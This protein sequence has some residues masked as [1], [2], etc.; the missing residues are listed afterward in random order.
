MTGGGQSQ[1]TEGCSL[2]LISIKAEGEEGEPGTKQSVGRESRTQPA[3]QMAR[4]D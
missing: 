3:G 1:N 2:A 4:D